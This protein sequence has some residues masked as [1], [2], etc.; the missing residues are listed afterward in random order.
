MAT[1]SL[2]SEVKW[3]LVIN[4]QKHYEDAKKQI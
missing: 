2:L 3:K 4:A 1:P